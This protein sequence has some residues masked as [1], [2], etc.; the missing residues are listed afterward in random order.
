MMMPKK[1]SFV[2]HSLHHHRPFLVDVTFLETGKPKPIVIL[3]HGFKGFKDWGPF[4]LMADYFAQQGFVFLKFNFSHNGTTLQDPVNFVDLDAFGHDNHSIQLDDAGVV[5]DSLGE[6]GLSYPNE[7]N[8]EELFL[9]G[10]SRGGS[11]A[12]LKAC[13]DARVKKV[14]TWAAVSNLSSVYSEEEVKEWKETGVRIVTNGRTRQLMPVYYQYYE[15]LLSHPERLSVLDVIP[16][17]TQPLLILHGDKDEAVPISHAYEIHGKVANSP[18]VVL[19]GMNHV[20]GGTHPWTLRELPEDFQ[21][22][23]DWTIRFLKGKEE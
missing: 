3:L 18:M 12:L 21:K 22:V 19:P 13:E 5:I 7:I 20:F 16:R 4:H 10:H 14:V 23:C 9:I 8:T 11:M 15:E 2:L 6:L 17:L 1:L